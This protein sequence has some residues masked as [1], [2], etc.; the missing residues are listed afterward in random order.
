[1]HAYTGITHL[2]L[3]AL[4]AKGTRAREA[5]RQL[6][7]AVARPGDTSKDT[8]GLAF[9]RVRG[10]YRK[11]VKLLKKSRECRNR[12]DASEIYT[13][14]ITGVRIVTFLDT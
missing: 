13:S 8:Q 11:P 10:M 6:T 12:W 5:D 2:T 4:R 14:I 7:Q 1:M 3:A 9:A